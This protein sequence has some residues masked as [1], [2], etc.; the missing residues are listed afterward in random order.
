MPSQRR[1]TFRNWTLP[2]IRF[3][4]PPK[5]LSRDQFCSGLCLGLTSQ[6]SIRSIIYVELVGTTE[7]LIFGRMAEAVSVICGALV[8]TTEPL[9][10]DTMG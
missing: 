5:T 10:F 1:P 3:K 8:G 6:S 2:W 9:I 4:N 7:S